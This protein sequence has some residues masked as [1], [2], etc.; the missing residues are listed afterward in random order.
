MDTNDRRAIEDLFEKLAGVGRQG[1]ERDPEAEAF[2]QTRMERQPGAAY[3][4][5]QT[6]VVQEQALER[7]QA[8]VEALES[9]VQRARSGGGLFG[10]LF[11][12]GRPSTPQPQPRTYHRS[13]WGSG[14]GHHPAARHGGGGFLAGAAQTAV[15]VAGGV[16]L[17]NALADMF[18]GDEAGAADAFGAE[19]AAAEMGA[20][21]GFDDFEV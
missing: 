21:E 12:G 4:M 20:D 14:A 6:I 8:R 1:Q 18:A 17:G 7:M 9:E 3:Y 16:L 2:I 19:E 11:G 10:S 5:A 13:P 15:G